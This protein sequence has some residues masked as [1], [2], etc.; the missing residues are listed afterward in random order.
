MAG[1]E[2]QTF[3]AA[4]CQRCMMW[5]VIVIEIHLGFSWKYVV[6]SSLI[7]SWIVVL[8]KSKFRENMWWTDSLAHSCGMK[9]V[10]TCTAS[11]IQKFTDLGISWKYVVNNSLIHSCGIK[12]KLVLPDF[13]LIQ[14]FSWFGFWWKYVV[15]SSIK[16]LTVVC[17]KVRRPSF[18]RFWKNHP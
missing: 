10:K 18:P 11:L 15:N 1:H 2:I 4:F 5:V 9:Q 16:L 3:F 12:S 14:K 7:H 6:N 17:I 13:S 8:S